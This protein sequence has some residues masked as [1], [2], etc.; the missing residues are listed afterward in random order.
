MMSGKKRQKGEER[1]E[2]KDEN[3][4]RRERKGTEIEKKFNGMR[5]RERR[6]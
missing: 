3:S 1:K 4:E 2:L 6:K 5:I